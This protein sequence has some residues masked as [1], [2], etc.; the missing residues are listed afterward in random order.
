M[1]L[2]EFKDEGNSHLLKSSKAAGGKDFSL[3]EFMKKVF[4]IVGSFLQVDRVGVYMLTDLGEIQLAISFDV[5]K[6][7]VNT[8]KYRAM[9]REYANEYL[10]L[11]RQD[12][13]QSVS[14]LEIEGISPFIDG[15]KKVRVRSLIDIPLKRRGNIIGSLFCDMNTNREW[16]PDEKQF[17]ASVG[18]ILTLALEED[19]LITSEQRYGDF[20]RM[21]EA[22]MLLLD[23]PT[24]AIIDANAAACEFYEFSIDELKKLSIWDL[25]TDSKALA[26]VGRLATG[27][28]LHAV[29]R[30]RQASGTVIDVEIFASP[31]GSP[32]LEMLILIVVDITEALAAKSKLAEAL[33]Q[34]NV[35]LEGAVELVS[36]VVE[37]RDP[38][39]AGHQENVR[40]LATEIAER[41]RLGEDSVRAV[42]IVGLLHDVGKVSIP[43]EILSE[44]GN[45]TDLEW[46]LI[47]RHPVMG[48][49]IFRDVKL[50]GPIADIV[51]HHHERVTEPVILKASQDLNS[52]WNPKSR[53]SP[54]WW[55]LWCHADHIGHQKVLGKQSKR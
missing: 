46:S 55:K 32:G 38:Y 28:T 52:R 25:A 36:K 10:D 51:K 3:D 24:G 43:A 19:E 2:Q 29:T 18:N 23:P 8:E 37:V 16:T 40:R 30:Q 34:V 12:R 42:R 54:I 6:D 22:V 20:F 1:R 26:E 35:A 45:L 33:R 48:Y 39:T 31:L 13:I 41:L 21:N 47:K 17:V 49:E 7:K 50:G 5:K 27:E 15:L 9:N 11:I 14:N 4:E 44:P 53:L